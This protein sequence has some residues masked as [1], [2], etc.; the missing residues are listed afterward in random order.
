MIG[1]ASIASS[2]EHICGKK[3]TVDHALSCPHGVFPTLTHNEIMDLTAQLLFE[4]CSNVIIEPSLQPLS[5]KSLNL[6]RSNHH[7]GVHL[8]IRAQ[9]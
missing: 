8:D 3:F 9:A 1:L 5:E 6:L 2:D 7:D 4:V